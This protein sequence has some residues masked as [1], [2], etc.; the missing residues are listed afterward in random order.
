MKL[1]IEAST[2]ATPATETAMIVSNNGN[3]HKTNESINIRRN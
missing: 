2:T 3:N 1:K